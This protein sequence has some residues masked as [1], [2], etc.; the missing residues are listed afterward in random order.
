[1]QP[2]QENLTAAGCLM[3]LS[4]EVAQISEWHDIDSNE[5]RGRFA[6]NREILNRVRSS[7]AM[8]ADLPR[9]TS[10]MPYWFPAAIYGGE[11]AKE[12]MAIFRCDEFFVAINQQTEKGYFWSKYPS[13]TKTCCDSRH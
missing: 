5:V 8:S 3:F 1:M 2:R 9:R 7:C 10:S 11:A 4:L 6:G 13:E 12:G